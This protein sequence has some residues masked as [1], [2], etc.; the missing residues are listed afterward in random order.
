MNY[1]QIRPITSDP[2]FKGKLGEKVFWG[3]VTE[4]SKV[5]RKRSIYPS[6]AD[7][8]RKILPK[9]VA[10]ES[11]ITFVDT[12]LFA[13]C[14]KGVALLMDRMIFLD[15]SFHL[16][17][18]KSANVLFFENLLSV[19]LHA[20]SIVL[21]Y[22]KEYK[23]DAPTRKV[24]LRCGKHKNDMYNFFREL[25]SRVG[26]PVFEEEV[27]V[28]PVKTLHDTIGVF[29]L[30]M[31]YPDIGMP[32]RKVAFICDPYHY[33]VHDDTL[34]DYFGQ[35]NEGLCN[36][37][38]WHLP[39]DFPKAAMQIKSPGDY[40]YFT[41]CTGFYE[42]SCYTYYYSANPWNKDMIVKHADFLVYVMHSS[43]L[44]N[45]E[46][47]SDVLEDYQTFA[48]H[49]KHPLV[50]FADG[51]RLDN[52]QQKWIRNL[53]SDDGLLAEPEILFA[54]YQLTGNDAVERN[55][56]AKEIHLMVKNIMEK[57]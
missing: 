2:R 10:V 32:I 47:L 48:S 16:S 40:R 3:T 9:G 45:R 6:T 54:I 53:L 1:K 34:L 30:K 4:W 28:I 11:V 43:M 35:F 46:I 24:T 26:E 37:F 49:F 22:M 55:I 38:R 51:Y 15:N 17:G 41:M 57:G 13:N 12:S 8:L 14:G 27:E 31:E 33:T 50:F 39:A 18:T 52:E 29:D 21:R 5:I 44:S 20:F 42:R 56:Q 19:E 25:L 36:C 23:K 7:R